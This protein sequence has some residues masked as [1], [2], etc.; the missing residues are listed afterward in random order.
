[1][2][3]L[4]EGCGEPLLGPARADRRYHGSACRKL[5]YLRRRRDVGQL[6]AVV[7]QRPPDREGLSEASLVFNVSQA[8]E[9]NW[10][11]AVWLLERR[12]PERWAR[13]GGPGPVPPARDDPFAEVDDLAARRRNHPPFSR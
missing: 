3:R 8:A 2:K 4:C 13:G 1:M 9:K 7:P 10:R 6:A 11:A 12:Y 5:A